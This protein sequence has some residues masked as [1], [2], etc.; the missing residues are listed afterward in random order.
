MII[1]DLRNN[2]FSELG[3]IFINLLASATSYAIYV[4]ME[5][6]PKTENHYAVWSREY[7]KKND[8]AMCGVYLPKELRNRFTIAVEKQGTSKRE[9]LERFIRNYISEYEEKSVEA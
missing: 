7:R 2:I 4:W 3:K 9:V 1:N 5:Q 8:I 6:P